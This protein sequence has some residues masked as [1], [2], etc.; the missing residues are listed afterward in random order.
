MIAGAQL[1]SYYGHHSRLRGVPPTS[2]KKKDS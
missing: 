2:A 1:N